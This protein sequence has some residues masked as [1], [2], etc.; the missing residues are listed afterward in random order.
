MAAAVIAAMIISPAAI[1]PNIPAIKA[2]LCTSIRP[3]HGFY[4][5]RPALEKASPEKA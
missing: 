3:R 2:S 5:K 4:R 1:R